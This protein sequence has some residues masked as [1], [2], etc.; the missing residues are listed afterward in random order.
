M[1]TGDAS[2][3]GIYKGTY[4]STASTEGGVLLP[5]LVHFVELDISLF[6]DSCRPHD[7]T[8]HVTDTQTFFGSFIVG[9]II[10]SAYVVE[11]RMAHCRSFQH[12]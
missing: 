7:N 6:M 2:G 1:D 3:R 4:L 10:Q 11:G 8:P 5:T 9:S 12:N